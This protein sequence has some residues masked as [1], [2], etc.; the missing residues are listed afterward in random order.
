M[1][2]LKKFE[3]FEIKN[4]AGILAGKGIVSCVDRDPVTGNSSIDIKDTETGNTRFGVNDYDLTYHV[5]DVVYP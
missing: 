4:Q 5:G 2:T 3:Q 1:S